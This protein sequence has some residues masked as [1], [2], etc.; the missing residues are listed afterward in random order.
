M[1][2]I[3]FLKIK[4]DE[5]REEDLIEFLCEAIAYYEESGRQKLRLLQNYDDRELFFE[6]IEYEDKKAFDCD[7]KRVGNDKKMKKLLERWREILQQPPE[8]MHFIDITHKIK[9]DD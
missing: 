6:I 2:H 7:S 3:L 1:R 5:G 9:P 8:I 4:V